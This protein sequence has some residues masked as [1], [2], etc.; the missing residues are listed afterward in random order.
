MPSPSVTRRD[1]VLGLGALALGCGPRPRTT[2]PPAAD[3]TVA[4]RP[5]DAVFERVIAGRVTVID[6][7]ATW[8]EPCRESIPKVI[9]LAQAEQAR[10]LV[11][12]GVHVGHGFEQALAFADEAGIDYA[13]FADPEF[14]LSQRFGARNVPTVVVLDR[15]GRELHRGDEVDDD[16]RGA[17]STALG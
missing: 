11:V 1:L 15:D 6:F 13:L 5:S 10:G 7:W 8:C 12:V 4:L 14:R 2:T 3:G 9:A 16:L 17:I